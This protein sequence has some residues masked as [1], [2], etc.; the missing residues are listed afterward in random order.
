VDEDGTPNRWSGPRATLFVDGRARL[1]EL[2]LSSTLPGGAPQQ[3]EVRVDGRLANRLEVGS[4]WQRLR[5]T[6]PPDGASAPRRID[7]LVSPTWVPA[8]VIHNDDRRVLG[9]KV[10]GIH[11]VRGPREDR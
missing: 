3:V 5:L 6:L 8:D 9:V 4:E 11:V 1:V 7:L 2:P 10:A